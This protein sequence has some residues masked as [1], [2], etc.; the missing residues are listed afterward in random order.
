VDAMNSSRPGRSR[1]PINRAQSGAALLL[2]IIVIFVLTIMGLALLFTTTTEFQ[3]A[4]AETTLNKAFYAA[5]SGIQYGIF[6]G[7]KA[8]YDAVGSTTSCAGATSFWCFDLPEL[9]P[10]ASRRIN[11]QVSPFRLNDYK[12]N[13][14][15]QI[16]IGS[17]PL[18]DVGYTFSSTST[19]SVLNT[20]KT[21]SVDLTIGPLPFS[22]ENAAK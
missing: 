15:S 11:V 3:I 2:A 4:G 1:H 5:D 7:K 13:L 12:L 8:K 22:I 9:S 19:D 16:N 10:S 6:Q 14:G 20:K 17:V 21:I 18:Y